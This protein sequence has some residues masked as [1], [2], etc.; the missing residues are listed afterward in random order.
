MSLRLRLNEQIYSHASC[1]LYSCFSIFKSYLMLLASYILAS[2]FVK[3][4]D[5]LPL[6]IRAFFQTTIELVEKMLIFRCISNML[7]IR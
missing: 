7:K 4:T 2:L 1:F 5:N 6:K 3:Q